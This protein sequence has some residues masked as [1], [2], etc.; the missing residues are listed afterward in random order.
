MYASAM[1][2]YLWSI[3]EI[4]ARMREPSREVLVSYLHVILR[5]DIFILHDAASGQTEGSSYYF[6]DV[7]LALWLIRGTTVLSPKQLSAS[8]NS[9]KCLTKP[10]DR[11]GPSPRII[12]PYTKTER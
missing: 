6:S 1:F 8:G 2:S 12:I 5:P 4:A 7:L 10:C 3:N 11:P 9:I